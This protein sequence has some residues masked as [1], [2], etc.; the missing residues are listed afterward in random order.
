MER[1]QHADSGFDAVVANEE[2]EV[3]FEWDEWLDR[4]VTLEKAVDEK[5]REE[6]SIEC[7]SEEPVEIHGGELRILGAFFPLENNDVENYKTVYD[8]HGDENERGGKLFFAPDGGEL[9]DEFYV[10]GPADISFVVK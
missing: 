4:D 8:Y 9:V 7:V 3:F 1:L 2:L 6:D 5:E 10:V